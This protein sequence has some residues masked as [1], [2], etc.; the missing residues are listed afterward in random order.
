MI[1]EEGEHFISSGHVTNWTWER[2]RSL[3]AQ[4]SAGQSELIPLLFHKKLHVDRQEKFRN[5]SELH[6]F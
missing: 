2:A 5:L 1:I 4:C 6:G 3:S